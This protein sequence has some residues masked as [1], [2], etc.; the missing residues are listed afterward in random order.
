MLARNESKITVEETD[1]DWFQD[2]FNDPGWFGKPVVRAKNESKFPGAEISAYDWFL[3]AFGNSGLF[4]EPVA[5]ATN[6]QDSTPVD[7]PQRVVRNLPL[8]RVR[9]SILSLRN[10]LSY[11]IDV[12]LQL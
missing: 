4:D 1:Y 5:R 10:S 8:R 7:T 12:R 11:F 9:P 3:N 6:V 2:A